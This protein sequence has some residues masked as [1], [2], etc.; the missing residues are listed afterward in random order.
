MRCWVIGPRLWRGLFLCAFAVAA[1]AALATGAPTRPADDD[2]VIAELP[3]TPPPRIVGTP[4]SPAIAARLAQLY[5]LRARETGDPRYLGYAQGLLG[6][7]WTAADA[8]DEILLLRATLHQ[9][10]HRFDDAL[11]DL[12]L[13]LA[14]TPAH[15][16][17]R[18]TR[19]TVLRVLGRYP[20][21]LAACPPGQG[22]SDLPAE[23]CRHAVR[24]LMGAVEAT[25]D[26]LE[27]LGAGVSAQPVDVQQWYWAERGELY[28]RLGD[29]AAAATAYESGI[30]LG[31]A[32]LG[33]RVALADLHLG[34]GEP[35]AAL[36][37]VGD[38]AG[39]DALLLRQALALKALTRPGH[40]PL[41]AGIREGQQAVRR[42]GESPHLREEALLALDYHRDAAQALRLAREN[43][44]QQREPADTRLL[45]RAARASGNR[46]VLEELKAWCLASGYR[47]A[48][49][50]WPR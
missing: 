48:V 31:G 28:E 20:E 46:A 3:R 7:G 12:D 19:A 21:A 2:E 43:W 39:I 40:E 38:A 49:L 14:R 29:R 47:D 24:G 45:W 23:L 13:L 32:T 15:R 10:Q 16:Q 44:V 27:A 36:A 50:E 9:A 34:A 42:R 22:P 33:L 17:A 11:A 1:P 41:V 6:S 30:R 8:P 26:A 4:V 35:S 25:R 5:V 37:A 18:L